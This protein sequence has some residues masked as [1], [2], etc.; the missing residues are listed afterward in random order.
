MGMTTTR[1]ATLITT[2]TFLLSV[3]LAHAQTGGGTTVSSDIS[4]FL[5]FINDYVVG[6]I[7]AIAFVMFLWGVFRYFIA[8][9]DSDENHTEGRQFILYAIIGFVLMASIWGIV[10]LL[11]AS[12]GIDGGTE[13]SLPT[14]TT[15]SGGGNN[16]F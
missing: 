15:G 16:G 2:L 13:P 6:L 10:N 4:A 1:R 12:T 9:G 8:G 7:F 3:S 11:Q 5:T 14:I